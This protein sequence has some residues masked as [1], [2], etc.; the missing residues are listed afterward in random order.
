M[1]TPSPSPLS[2]IRPTNTG[3]I[4]RPSA[5]RG[6]GR[7]APDP[8]RSDR[9]RPPSASSPPSTATLS[10]TSTSDSA[11]AAAVSNPSLNSVKIATVNVWYWTISKAPYSAS[12][13]SVTSRQPP[14]TAGEIWRRVTRQNVRHGPY[15]RLRAT[16]SSAGSTPPSEAATGRYTSGYSDSVMI[17]TAAGYPCSPGSSDTQPKPTTK[18]GMP[19]GSTSATAH[20]R[21][22]GSVVRSTHQA[23]ATPIAVHS[24]VHANARRTVFHSSTAVSWR[25]SRRSISPRP[26]WEAS[27]IRKTSGSS[28][29]PEASRPPAM[30]TSG[31]RLRPDQ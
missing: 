31:Q 22:P 28:T 10:R 1:G 8:P 26:G 15:P 7:R 21:R 9:P 11:Q 2:E 4:Q 27:L 5:T 12:R 13:P 6:A 25:S 14:S 24:T 17:S 3:A 18:S 16:S 20:Q 19:S 30:L 23:A 29:S